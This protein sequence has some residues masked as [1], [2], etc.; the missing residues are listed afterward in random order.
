MGSFIVVFITYLAGLCSFFKPWIGVGAYYL[1]ALLGP[2]Y[3]WWWLFD[4]LRSSYIV[5]ICTLVGV[6]INRLLKNRSD[7]T[8]LFNMQNLWVAV[9][10]GSVFISH[11][12]GAYTAG[13][14][15]YWANQ[16]FS[17]TNVIF[18]IYFCSTIELNKIYKLQML[19]IVFIVSVVY[20]TYWA[21]SQYF[22]QNWGGF[23]HGRL[24]G[25]IGND[26]GSVYGDENTFAMIFV[27]G[28]PFIYYLG[29][30]VRTLWLRVIIW[31]IVPFCWHAIFLTVSRGGLL[32]IGVTICCILYMS[33][34][35]SL[36]IP[37]LLVFFLFYQ[38]QAGSIME[39]RSSAIL[40]IEGERSAGD[41]LIAWKGGARMISSY[42]VSGVG[43]G[44]FAVALPDHIDTRNMVAHNTLIQFTA[45]S[46]VFA[47]LA[48][49]MIIF[50]F[51]R[52]SIRIR[53]WCT[54]N[55]DNDDTS[56]ISCYNNASMSSFV[57]LVI[58]SLFLS[59]NT[60]EV[61]FFLIL[62]NNSLT[63]RCLIS[64]KQTF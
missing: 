1:L 26:G 27:T 34:K 28:F 52:N 61:F 2:Q 9:L 21:N 17:V 57:G 22:N 58:C 24:M 30:L 64:N 59:L 4:D 45:E 53:S 11:F 48:Y 31:A 51:L 39:S 50:C 13:P 5:G 20:L 10:W 12:I 62:I 54:I 7:F 40:N 47:G 56:K 63:Q 19:F 3:I 29:Q 46:G 35:K 36:I 43:V 32:G 25:P 42:P 16:V 44:K 38:F 33:S 6:F 15:D 8:L 55:L 18:V 60:Y 23:N 14:V 37:L 49:L 41:R